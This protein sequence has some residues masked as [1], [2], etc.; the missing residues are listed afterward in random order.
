[1]HISSNLASLFT[2]EQSAQ[3][4]K[5]AS[6][7]GYTKEMFIAV[8]GFDEA[9]KKDVDNIVEQL[10]S[11]DSVLSVQSRFEIRDEVK[12]YYKLFYPLLADFN[13]E[14]F[15][16]EKVNK[17]LQYLYDSQFSSAFYLPI[18]AHDPLALFTLKNNA[19][20]GVTYRGSYMALENY[21]YLIRV[22]TNVEPSQMKEAELLYTKCQ[23]I[24]SQ[25]D[26]VSAF[27]PFFYTVENSAYIKKDVQIIIILSVVLLLVVYYILL[28]NLSL[29]VETLT[30][31]FSSMVFA[32][33][34]S[35]ILFNDFHILAL[36][37]GMSITAVSIDY[38]LHYH[39]HG[40]FHQKKKVDKNVLYGFLTTTFAFVVF[41]FIPIPLIAQISFFAVLSL[42]FAYLLFTFVFPRIGIKPYGNV[43][44]INSSFTKIP[45]NYIFVLSV[46]L[47][48]YSA[49]Q[50]QLDSNI[51]NLD[52]QNIELRDKEALFK[53]ANQAQLSPIIVQAS[54]RDKL[55]YN[56]HQI[57]TKAPNTFSLASFVLDKQTC[58]EKKQKLHK[59][60]F[61]VLNKQVNE[62][63]ANIGYK[64]D[65]FQ[66]AYAFT[67][68]LPDCKGEYLDLFS[69]YNLGVYESNG[70]FFTMAFIDEPKVI[71]SFTFV[72]TINLQELFSDVA[73]AMY[74]SLLLF[75]SLV[76]IVV[77]ILLIMS[78]KKQFLY[79]LN[80]ILFPI[81]L[82]LAVLV[83]I[84]DINL[85][86]LFTLII[87]IAI[88]IDYGIYMSN[89]NQKSNT[90]L[91]I[92]YSL[93]STFAGF[94]VLI[95][96]SIVA[97]NSIGVVICLGIL[98]IF[99]LTKVMK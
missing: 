35:T 87:L 2:T 85:M 58:L 42:S 1:I 30:A 86:H 80:Y 59:Y 78:V 46:L 52:Y 96:S 51:R 38:L 12:D 79:A 13:D 70:M 71:K 49:S 33:L 8:K 93:L 63:A 15:T 22:R 65:Y 69:S 99:V 5:V 10:R 84:M 40:F 57:H 72:S 53:N 82:T 16:S 89:T 39:F 73:Q 56:L 97:L 98:S 29:L 45:A 64:K 75:S 41:A 74:K 24:F 3:K 77:L 81:S 14:P 60:D 76:I 26:N 17:K 18:D 83:S 19:N 31:L 23:H 36:A 47:F 61:E 54:S 48:V 32:S 66:N 95:F 68:E 62:E 7:L 20:N 6:N 92:R 37:F 90:I 55:L 88:G 9:A 4:M 34:V 43:I 50:I 67:K 44:H 28:K 11:I 25:Y 27:A 21:G 91:A 94:G